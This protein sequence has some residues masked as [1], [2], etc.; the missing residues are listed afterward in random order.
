MSVSIIRNFVFPN[1]QPPS[2]VTL[3][4]KSR[5]L[6]KTFSFF[7]IKTKPCLRLVLCLFFDV[8][9]LLLFYR[10]YSLLVPNPHWNLTLKRQ[11]QDNGLPLLPVWPLRAPAAIAT[12]AAV[13]GPDSLPAPAPLINLGALA[14][15]IHR[16]VPL[17]RETSRQKWHIER[18]LDKD[19]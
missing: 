5:A 8:F 3:R 19:S 4:A 16:R 7:N 2:R 10:S 1:M 14:W 6:Q 13:S 15:T 11:Q 18:S 12:A 17:I 9:F